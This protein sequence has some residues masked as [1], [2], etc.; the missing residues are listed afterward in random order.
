MKTPGKMITFAV[1]SVMAAAGTLA[2]AGSA[3]AETPQVQTHAVHRSVAPPP[4]LIGPNG[5]KPTEWGMASISLDSSTG[6]M[7][8]TAT[9]EVGGGTWSYGTTG[10]TTKGC[11]SNYIHP[12]KKHSASIAIANA[13]DKDIRGKDVWAK[14]YGKAGA[15]H[16]CYTYWGVYDD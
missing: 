16:T 10:T 5:E 13:S 11:Y 15:A 9:K 6:S 1:M 8:P 2:T 3:V 7:A 4:E 14:A 12:S